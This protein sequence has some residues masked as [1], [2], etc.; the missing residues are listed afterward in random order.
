[1]AKPT[2][3][4]AIKRDLRTPKY[5]QRVVPDKSKEIPQESEEINLDEVLGI[6]EHNYLSGCPFCKNKGE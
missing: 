4:S 5:Q 3:E 1:M 2:N 6:C